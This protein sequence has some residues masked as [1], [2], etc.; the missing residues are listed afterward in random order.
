MYGLIIYDL[1]LFLGVFVT[2]DL[3]ANLVYI[4]I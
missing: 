4:S 2:N 3:F 1:F